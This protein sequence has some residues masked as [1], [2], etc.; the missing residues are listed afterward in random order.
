VDLTLYDLVTGEEVPM[1]GGYDE[2]SP[3]SFADYPGGTSRQRW[4]RELLRQAMEAQGFTV[5]EAEWWHFDYKDWKR[6]R[7]GN[8]RFEELGGG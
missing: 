8:Q 4:F 1:T 2:M 6:Y 5:Y 3:R 7:I